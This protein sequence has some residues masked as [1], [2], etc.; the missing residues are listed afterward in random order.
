V[1]QTASASAH[2]LGFLTV[3]HETNGYLGGYLVTNQWGRPLEFRLSTSVQ[4]NRIQQIIYG[5]TLETYICADLIGKTLVEKTGTNAELIFTDR[6]PVLDL[7]LHVDVPVAYFA[8]ANEA[9]VESSKPVDQSA[10]V[11]SSGVS[12][13]RSSCARPARNGVGPAFCHPSFAADLPAARQLLDRL[14]GSL[15]LAEPFT[16]IRE[17]IAE[18]R[19]MG[20]TSRAA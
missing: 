13:L 6:E 19:K 17:A 16:R 11:A 15:D 10:S 8:M 7:R 2:N 12:S 14:E 18:A 3:L 4:P 1:A 20:V 9:S 5:A